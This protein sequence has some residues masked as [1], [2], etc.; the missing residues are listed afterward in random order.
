[1]QVVIPCISLC[2][3]VALLGSTNFSEICVSILTVVAFLPALTAASCPAPPPPCDSEHAQFQRAAKV[4][5]GAAGA[6]F[7]NV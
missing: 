5:A 3:G 4:Q 2:W 7:V 1:M 6:G